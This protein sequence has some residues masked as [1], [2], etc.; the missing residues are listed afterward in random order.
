MFN[1]LLKKAENGNEEK[2]ENEQTI[3]METQQPEQQPID[4]EE[5]RRRRLA[6][7]ALSME[8][9]NNNNNNNSNSPNMKST[10]QDRMDI[11]TSPD[12]TGLAPSP[13]IRSPSLTLS[14]GGG[15]E[16]FNSPNKKIRE[17]SQPHD[18][19]PKA[20]S[21][22]PTRV[23][24]RE[25]ESLALNLNLEFCL[26]VTLRKEG[27]DP[28][29]LYLGDDLDSMGDLLSISNLSE[30]I[31]ARLARKSDIDAVSYLVAC[32]K[33]VVVKEGACNESI[34]HSLVKCK[35]QIVSFL[36]TCLGMPEM[37]DES[38]ARSLFHFATFLA[39]DTSSIS[40]LLIKEVVDEL[41]KQ[42]YLENVASQLL[43]QVTTQLS[44]SSSTPPPSVF[45]QANRM[46]RSVLDNFSTPLALLKALCREKRLAR[47]V[48]DA[49]GFLATPEDL[50]SIPNVYNVPPQLAHNA[51]YIES[52]G[53]KGAAVEHH[54]FLG[55]VL[56]IAPDESDPQL[57]E[58]FK[59]SYRQTRNIL[60]G[61]IN[62]I[63]KVAQNAQSTV[64]EVLLALLKCGGATKEVAMTWLRQAI[65][66]N[67][68]A[69][70]DR[71]SPLLASSNGFMVGLA[72]VALQ[73]A[74][75]VFQDMEKLQKVK[76][77]FLQSAEGLELF[78]AD[79]TALSSAAAL[80]NPQPLE[81]C[82]ESFTFISQSFFMCWRAVHLGIVPQCTRYKHIVR[83]LSHHFAGLQS[84]DQH[85]IAY[86]TMKSVADSLLLAPGLLSDL[87]AFTSAGA[88]LLLRAFHVEESYE[89]H[90][91]S[92]SVWLLSP[93]DHSPEQLALLL[94]LPE[95]FVDDIM[96]ILLFVAKT[97]PSV[98]RST[99]LNYVLSL[100]LFFL[101]R[102]WAVKSPHLRAKF[103][104]LLF[105]VFL[106]VAERGMHDTYTN[107]RSV[108]GVNAG[109][110]ATHIEA[111]K[112][113]A[114]AL[115]LL[116]GDV[117]RTG[118]YEK[119]SN[120]RSI[121]VVLKHLWTLPTHRP[122]FRGIATMDIDTRH[123]EEADADIQ[124]SSASGAHG[125]NSFV[126]FANG[127]LNEANYLVAG[128]MDKLAD[129]RKT[130]MLMQNAA[131]WSAL[132]EDERN[133]IKERHENNESECK[134]Y[135]GLCLDT[136]NML[137]YLTSDE[138][139]RTPFLFEEI[140]PRF[141]STLLNVLQR[142]VGTK[143]LEIKVD[144]M[145]MYNFQPR[146]CLLE[147]VQTMLHFHAEPPFWNAV[148]RDAFYSDGGPLRKAIST[149]IRLGLLSN[150][151]VD[152]LRL[153]YEHV[154]KCRAE[155]V[156]LDSLVEDAP[157][158]FLDPLM[159]TLMRDPV[160]LPTSKT[161]VDRS[162][163]A[164]HLLN[165]ETDPFNRQPLT[166]DMVEPQPELKAKIQAWLD[167]KLKK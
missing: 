95:H 132:P 30:V 55:R 46:M 131:E 60:E 86:F 15:N 59:D 12:T 49:P 28:S 114:P 164:Q 135:A 101:R 43:A 75:P 156:D 4:K 104:E 125:Q 35:E 162:T 74:R 121:M 25:L 105:Y 140:L 27:V 64:A 112:F 41:Q 139:I 31:C 113:L 128:T 17:S 126:R 165:V 159:D 118:F 3:A 84:G 24:S 67:T 106:P 166:I 96:S 70:K 57:R 116:Y 26:Q 63:R 2:D 143:S 73:L 119:L 90:T 34:R 56:R 39:E 87:L 153:L 124:Q 58:M 32:Y 9:N 98:L 42:D 133:M 109:M 50:Q 130:Q 69:E 6:R 81:P 52:K 146:I 123:L 19:S 83:N 99:S 157:F 11:V 62:D 147:I 97:A 8:T 20:S 80:N 137:N 68:E 66:N 36:A 54:T 22:S 142:I 100:V 149:V 148:A 154:Q 152:Q 110:L 161:V 38:S 103:G 88:S 40:V 167:S 71:P 93:T 33:R 13:M 65:V 89:Q 1:F 21:L 138:V 18:L 145:E 5:I 44:A 134:T 10:S 47:A 129:I 108:D 29:C 92:R 77:N 102:P 155:V 111:Q 151:D 144:N 150:E 72:A 78:P 76:V 115:L 23:L 61:R 85:A 48:G 94:R 91:L 79:L 16:A 53:K 163:I 82:N 160:R 37:F 14:L 51:F 122:A 136:L 127:L 120:R 107:E 117:E 158:E 141:T 7:V 45:H